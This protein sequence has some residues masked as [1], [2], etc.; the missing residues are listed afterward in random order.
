MSKGSNYYG[1]YF[2]VAAI[3]FIVP[4]FVGWKA[5]DNLKPTTKPVPNVDASGVDHAVWDYLLKANVTNGLVDYV[6]MKKDYLFRE[7]IRELGACDPDKLE[8]EDEK[9][10]LACNAYNAFVINGVITHKIYDTVDGRGFFDF[11]EHIFAGKTVSLN[12]IEHNMIRPTFKEPRIHVG[13]VCAARSCP[14]IRAEAF[15]G[16]RVREQLQDQSEQFTDNRKYV[17]YDAENKELK[18]SPI[19]NWYGDDW[20][21]RYPNGVRFVTKYKDR[22]GEVKENVHTGSS[23]VWISELTTDQSVKDGIAKVAA[24]EA[25]VAFFKYDWALNSQADPSKP[26]ESKKK[27][28]GFGSSSIPDE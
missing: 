11:K 22:D 14:A 28:G 15:V 1:G 4:L 6:A 3:S 21:E 8:T 19:L 7:Y 17:M 2:W 20:N 5:F 16:S 9:L 27:S 23:L 12:D 13:L 18:L 25:K 26:P 10:A 24:G